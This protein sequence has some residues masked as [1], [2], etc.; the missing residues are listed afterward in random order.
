M[1]SGRAMSDRVAVVCIGAVTL[2]LVCALDGPL[3]D[4][5][6]VAAP[7]AVLGSGGP[8]ATAAVTL[9]R[10][11]VSTAFVGT[12]GDD[13]AGVFMLDR[14]AGEGVDVSAVRTVPGRSAMSAILVDGMTG[15]RSIAAYYGTV[16]AASIDG[17]VERMCR[18]ALWIHVDHLGW[19][20]IPRLRAAEVGTP[21]SV[22]H[23]NPTPDLDLSMVRLY[24]PTE[25]R[26]LEWFPSHDL[27]AAMAAA[28]REGPDIVAVT[29]GDSGSIAAEI[30]G[31]RRAHIRDHTSIRGRRGEHPGSR[32]RLSWR[33]A[34]SAG[35][36]LRP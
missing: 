29:R 34:R 36:G 2:D 18:S 27:E 12:I 24:A 10:L 13:T 1:A 32:R 6:R 9:A 19:S 28:M 15:H 35:A 3:S 17:H 20:A 5:Q 25:A 11:G 31:G 23:G 26:L 21:I 22:D 14:L 8:A 30:G 16:G 7:D 33:A 4:D